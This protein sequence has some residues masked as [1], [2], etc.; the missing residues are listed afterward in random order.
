RAIP[1]ANTRIFPKQHM[2]IKKNWSQILILLFK[3]RD[4]LRIIFAVSQGNQVQI[5]KTG[6]H[7]VSFYYSP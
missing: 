3:T 7:V 2:K 4:Q 1:E 6:Y 5:S